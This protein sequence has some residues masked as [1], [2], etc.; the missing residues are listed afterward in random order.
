MQVGP[1]RFLS[2]RTESMQVGPTVSISLVARLVPGGMRACGWDPPTILLF[3]QARTRTGVELDR[4]EL[5]GRG[6]RSL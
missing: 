2:T 3:P 5:A 6:P 4:V 1:R